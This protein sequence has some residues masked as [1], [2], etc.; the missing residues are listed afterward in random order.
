MEVSEEA[1]QF[2]PVAEKEDE[3]MDES[4]AAPADEAEEPAEEPEEELAE[5]GES[6]ADWPHL[7]NDWIKALS[8][9][10]V[11]FYTA[12]FSVLYKLGVNPKWIILVNSLEVMNSS[13]SFENKLI[14]YV[15]QRF[16]FS[17]NL[18]SAKK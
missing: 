11:S 1:P 6:S 16:H 12:L 15:L 10:Q 2:S 5:T 13:S 9:K 3:S 17:N 18:S 7:K 14:L 4:T 8:L